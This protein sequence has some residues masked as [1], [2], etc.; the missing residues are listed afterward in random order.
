MKKINI[1][2]K[3]SPYII[4]QFKLDTNEE[5]FFTMVDPLKLLIPERIDL[6]AKIKY[7]DS[8][9]RDI[10]TDHYKHLYRKTIEAFSEGNYQ[11]PGQ[12]GKNSFAKYEEVFKELNESIKKAGVDTKKS[13]IPVGDNGAILDGAHRVA[14]SIYYK[15]QVPVVYLKNICVNYDSQYFKNR[16]LEEN[17]ID[18][19]ML[20]YCKLKDVIAICI[21]PKCNSLNRDKALEIIHKNLKVIYEKD[22]YLNYNG[23]RN[24][25]IEVYRHQD[26]IG[27]S[28]NKHKGVYQKLDNC[29]L[30]N[31]S[32]KVILIENTNDEVTNIKSEIRDI[33]KMGNHCIHSTDDR[34]ETI[35]LF[36]L[37]ANENTINFLNNGDPDCFSSLQE[38]IEKLK[39]VCKDNEIN[40]EDIV[41][42]SSSVLALY[43]IRENNDLDFLV[44]DLLIDKMKSLNLETHNSELRYYDNSL[45]DLLYNPQNYFIYNELKFL[46]LSIVKKMKQK[47]NEKKDKDDVVL[48][49]H[50]NKNNFKTL[51]KKRKIALKRKLR[52]VKTNLKI[53]IKLVLKKIGC[54]DILKKYL[55]K[56]R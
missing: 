16:L 48:I 43:G 22:V 56:K 21:W 19:M 25:M 38:E 35:Q 39:K 31:E 27:D 51:L 1:N 7:I 12:S 34:E 41:I 13:I 10:N 6:I 55:K 54:Y 29:Y 50:L 28:T 5:Y 46:S 15:K 14:L 40:L 4:E 45:D 37:V 26:W 49:N 33:L 17:C 20:E 30:K 44:S 9:N 36:S 52:N 42:D 11:E 32:L 18:E 24:F 8:I 3:I 2:Q 53:K 23:L 47:R